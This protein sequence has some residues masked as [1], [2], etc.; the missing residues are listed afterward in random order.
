MKRKQQMRDQLMSFEWKICDTFAFLFVTK[1][2]HL[3]SCD[4]LLEE[5]F[6][7]RSPR[8]ERNLIA[9]TDINIREINAKH[10]F[11]HHFHSRRVSE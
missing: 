3:I 8:N 5:L 1:F 9:N 7:R 11:G 6:V 10:I 4:I 2:F